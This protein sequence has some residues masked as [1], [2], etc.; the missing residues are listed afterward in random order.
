[1][2]L[3]KAIFLSLLLAGCEC[4]PPKNNQSISINIELEPGSLDPRKVRIL[5]D[6]NLVRTFMDGLMRVS[7]WGTTE[8][9]LADHNT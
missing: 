2:K 7:L 6:V 4:K 8:L 9:A 3:Y 5:N 1:M